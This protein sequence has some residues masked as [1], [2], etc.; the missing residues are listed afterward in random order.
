MHKDVRASRERISRRR[1]LGLGGAL[2]LSGLLAACGIDTEARPADTKPAGTKAA[3]PKVTATPPAGFAPTTTSGPELVAK[4]DSVG[5]CRLFSAE[6]Q[7]PYWFDVDSIR[8]DIREDRPG[9][10]LRLALRVYDQECKPV[11]NSVVELWHCDAGGVYSGY[12]VSSRSGQMPM[13]QET[14]ISDGS[15]SKGVTESKPQDDAT[16]LRGAQ[17]AD[18]NG[19]VQFTTI[20]PGWYVGRTVHIHFKVHVNKSN[21]MTSQLYFDDALNHE[22][23]RSSPYSAHTGRDTPN[24]RDA[25]FEASNVIAVDRVEDGYFAYANLGVNVV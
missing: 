5:S 20:Y 3:A 8:S 4:L 11:P 22:V 14:E 16:Y 13:M 21:V 25:I 23:Y 10:T 19:I 18:A 1:A 15:Y 17:V 7:G 2:S 12:E 24:E 6:M 9:T